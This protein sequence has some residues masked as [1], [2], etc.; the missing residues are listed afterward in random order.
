MSGSLAVLL[1]LFVV[2]DDDFFG[3]IVAHQF[4]SD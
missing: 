2:E 1:L 4:A 3:A